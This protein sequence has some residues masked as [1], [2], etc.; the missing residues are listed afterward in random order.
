MATT[1]FKVPTYI[2]MILI[3][4]LLAGL[5][6]WV[7]SLVQ[8]R[9]EAIDLK[10]TAAS[11]AYTTL[12][13]ELE[14]SQEQ[15]TELERSVATKDVIIAGLN[16]SNG[17]L[18]AIR[19][20]LETELQTIRGQKNAMEKELVR[21]KLNYSEEA[22][23]NVESVETATNVVISD[24]MREYEAITTEATGDKTGNR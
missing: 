11:T 6:L 10:D 14:R 2:K 18:S 3:L 5:F 21:Y 17:R 15:V 19:G 7:K 1:P 4:G 20:D 8:L 16:K 24:V 23:R 12:V 9:N 22:L 13:S